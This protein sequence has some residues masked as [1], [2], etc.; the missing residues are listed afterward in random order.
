VIE[1]RKKDNYKIFRK[2]VSRDKYF[3]SW[4][5]DKLSNLTIDLKDRI[6]DKYL[7][8]CEVFNRDGFK[9]QNLDCKSPNASLTFHHVKWQKNGGKDSPSNCVT[10]CDDCHKGFHN[11][12]VALKYSKSKHLPK[13]CRGQIEKL[14]KSD[15]VNW[16]EIRKQMKI[17]R[18]QVMATN[19]H[20]DDEDIYMV[21]KM[22]F[23]SFF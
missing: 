1:L 2:A 17:L 18:K 7:V 9:C 12:T 10:L 15:E 3:A 6:Y 13:K 4:P 14:T 16:K 21:L 23:D 20:M 11:A 19:K 22:F 5:E 8:K